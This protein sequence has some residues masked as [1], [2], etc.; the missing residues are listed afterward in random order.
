MYRSNYIPESYLGD[1]AC[2]AVHFREAT[3]AVVNIIHMVLEQSSYTWSR[4]RK[5]ATAALWLAVTIIVLIWLVVHLLVL[6]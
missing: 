5:V 4:A 2:G 6:F 3:L 1:S